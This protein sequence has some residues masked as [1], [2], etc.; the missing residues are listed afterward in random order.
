[1]SEFRL[2]SFHVGWTLLSNCFWRIWKNVIPK[3]CSS[4]CWHLQLS[5]H[6]HIP[7]Q[8]RKEEVITT[9]TWSIFSPLQPWLS[10]AMFRAHYSKLSH[11]PPLCGSSEMIITRQQFSR[12]CAVPAEVQINGT[13]QIKHERW[14]QTVSAGGRLGVTNEWATALHQ[15]HDAKINHSIFNTFPTR[16]LCWTYQRLVQDP[17]NIFRL[18]MYKHMF[19]ETHHHMMWKHRVLEYLTTRSDNVN[20][21]PFFLFLATRKLLCM[22]QGSR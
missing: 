12:L 17:Q 13:L 15:Y 9:V 6:D 8:V 19:T 22:I 16:V 11:C 4:K 5:C 1:M 14:H 2:V 18:L 3:K 10:T 7:P 21:K 20:V